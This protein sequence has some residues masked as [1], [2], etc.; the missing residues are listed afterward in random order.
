[1]FIVTIKSEVMVYSAD[2]SI[3]EAVASASV[4]EDCDEGEIIGVEGQ[5]GR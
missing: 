4:R 3:A 5:N 2:V 1:M